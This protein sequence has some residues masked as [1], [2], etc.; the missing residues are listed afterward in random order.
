VAYSWSAPRDERAQTRPC[1]SGIRHFCTYHGVGRTARGALDPNQG[2]RST[3][4]QVSAS[5]ETIRTQP[6]RLNEETCSRRRDARGSPSA[7]RLSAESEHGP[8]LVRLA[9]APGRHPCRPVAAAHRFRRRETDR[10]RPTTADSARPRLPREITRSDRNFAGHT[11]TASKMCLVV[12]LMYLASKLSD[13]GGHLFG[14]PARLSTEPIRGRRTLRDAA[15]ELRRSAYQ[16]PTGPVRAP[17]EMA[18]SEQCRR[19]DVR[20]RP[21]TCAVQMVAD[22]SW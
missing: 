14:F 2:C 22:D 16:D 15:G 5:A 4:S 10:S 18:T 13:R 21:V 7:A 19:A 12:Q 6:S 9:S 3:P 20:R 11:A 1:G 8:P 17:D